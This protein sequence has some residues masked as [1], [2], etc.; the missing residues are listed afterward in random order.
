FSFFNFRMVVT[1]HILIVK[2]YQH[3]FPPLFTLRQSKGAMGGW[4]SDQRPI[5]FF[6]VFCYSFFQTGILSK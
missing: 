4:G 5:L 6:R 1:L 3:Y 2:D